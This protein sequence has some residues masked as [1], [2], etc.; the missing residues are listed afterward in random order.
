MPRD[1]Y[2]RLP[3]A[4]ANARNCGQNAGINLYCTKDPL[5]HD[6]FATAVA[7]RVYKHSCNH[8]SIRKSVHTCR[9]HN[10]KPPE[11]LVMDLLLP[12]PTPRLSSSVQL[13]DVLLSCLRA[14]TRLSHLVLPNRFPRCHFSPLVAA[15]YPGRVQ[16][17]SSLSCIQRARNSLDAVKLPC[18]VHL[19]YAVEDKGKIWANSM[20]CVVLIANWRRR[21]RLTASEYAKM[22]RKKCQ[23]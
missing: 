5:G 15:A 16:G 22:G 13:R 14:R 2:F 6:V 8:K 1:A 11:Q 21:S 7:H 20:Y 3:D 9:H 4:G 19:Y 10:H 18:G 23:D 17:V 12:T